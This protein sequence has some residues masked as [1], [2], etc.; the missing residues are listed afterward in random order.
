MHTVAPGGNGVERR[1]DKRPGAG[2]LMVT[3]LQ[4]DSMMLLL[5]ARANVNNM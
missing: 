2:W 3:P 4:V 5:Q 1:K